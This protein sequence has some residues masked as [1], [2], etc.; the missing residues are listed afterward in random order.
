ME[1]F[2]KVFTDGASR[3]NPG[4]SAIGIAVFNE[5][6]ELIIDH[7]KFIGTGTKH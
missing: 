1:K 2:V 4:M 5:E 6:D 7:K 3:G